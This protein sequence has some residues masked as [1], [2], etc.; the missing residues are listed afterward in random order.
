MK[1][2]PRNVLICTVGTSLKTNL[3]RAAG[4]IAR[5][6]DPP[7]GV[8]RALLD[9]YARGDDDAVERELKKLDGSQRMCGAEINSI[10]SMLEKG[11]VVPECEL[12]FLRSDTEDGRRV[13]GWLQSYYRARG[14]RVVKTEAVEDLQD[15]DARRFRTRGLRNLARSMCRIVRER[16]PASCAIN[17]TGGYKAQI[18][19]AVVLGQALGVPVYY[20]HELFP[21]VIA[22]PPLP[23][24]L[25]FSLWLRVN[26]LLYELEREGVIEA[27][28][29]EHEWNEKLE[30]LVGREV[31]DG[32][33]YLELSPTGQVFHE[34]CQEMFRR[35]RGDLL[36]PEVPPH[37]KRP[38]RLER[39]GWPGEHPEIERYLLRLTKEV[40]QVRQCKSDYFNRDLSR[41]TGFRLSKGEIVG[42][43]SNGSY[44]V[45]FVVQTSARTDEE[46]LA[47][48]ALLRAW[49]AGR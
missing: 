35:L 13:G 25:D 47:V 26:E 48:L 33:E 32:R 31:V 9:A 38:P 17:A 29:Y 3:Q 16:S 23:V 11:Y 7:E 20:K 8:D 14:H 49:L 5:G 4:E 39:A 2:R 45:G 18:G 12:W 46:K 10:T 43:F 36:P 1:R 30:S 44:T 27:S 21:E 40:P 28:P 42:T 19:I 34:T 37:E 24:S 22:F 6:G 41:K 15:Q